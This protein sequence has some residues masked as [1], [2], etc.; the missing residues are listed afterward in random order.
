MPLTPIKRV[1]RREPTRIKPKA[2][3][4]AT[5]S[6]P[7]PPPSAK[8]RKFDSNT[9]TIFFHG[10]AL[11]QRGS[12]QRHVVRRDEERSKLINYVEPRLIGNTSGAM[13][14]SGLPG[15]GKSALVAEALPSILHGARLANINCM[16][17]TPD[18][19]YALIAKEFEY[20][21]RNARISKDEAVELLDNIFSTPTQSHVLVLD[22][23]DHIL[24]SDQEVLFKI[25]EWATGR[26]NLVVVGIAN[27]ID[28]TDRFLPRLQ[29][30]DLK[31]EVLPFK[32]YS[33]TDIV[34]IIEQRLKTLN[35]EQLIHPGAIRICAAKTAANSGDLR[36]AFDICRKAI[37]MVEE[38]GESL[39][40][41]KHVAKV[42]SQAFGGSDG[43]G[44][45]QDLQ[46]QQKAVLCV[47]CL[48]ERQWCSGD[49]LTVQKLYNEY[50][51]YANNNPAVSNLL[52][53][54]FSEVLSALDAQGL[55][56]IAGMCV[57][58]GLGSRGQVRLS[59]G[60][61]GAVQNKGQ[62]GYREEFG[63]RRVTARTPL[64]DVVTAL[65]DNP[66]LKQM[67]MSEL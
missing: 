5:S 4:T 10:K 38:E 66:P 7:T 52:Y 59:H 49:P 17:T 21:N 39:V 64:M 1:A 6:M 37:E 58:R 50:V 32:P 60:G 47:L 30:H 34:A 12:K 40:Q 33:T 45:I 19:I 48:V 51:R 53:S 25:F 13:Y 22:E 65:A 35:G 56:T 28:L 18:Q 43:R 27:A 55:I 44:Y 31:P 62:S 16:T 41:V 61:G 9:D 29:A 46:F 26:T 67:L 42:C 2:D 11:F 20:I 14:L 3:E 57:K 15:T 23:M 24:T 63:L 8:K 54:E 36:K